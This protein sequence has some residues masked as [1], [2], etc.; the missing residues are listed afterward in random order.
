MSNSNVITVE[1][2]KTFHS[3]LP[4][5]NAVQFKKNSVQLTQQDSN[6]TFKSGGYDGFIALSNDNII[7]SFDS[8]GIKYSIDK[9]ITY[10][11]SNITSGKY[12]AFAELSD[13]NVIASNVNG[14]LIYSTNKGVTWQ[15]LNSTMPACK[16]FAILSD[17]TIIAGLTSGGIKRSTDK[18]VTWQDSSETTIIYNI[19]RVLSDDTIVA[20]SYGSYIVKYSTDKG[21][22]WK[23]GNSS[24][25]GFPSDFTDIVVLSDDTLLAGDGGHIIYSKNKGVTW[26]FSNSTMTSVAFAELSDG[27]VIACDQRIEYSTDKGVTWQK[28]NVAYVSS[29]YYINFAVLSDDTVIVTHNRGIKYST[30][31][32]VTWQ[33]SIITSDNYRTLAVLSDDTIIVLKYSNSKGTRVVS[34]LTIEPYSLEVDTEPKEDDNKF[35]TRDMLVDT[36][37]NLVNYFKKAIESMQNDISTLQGKTYEYLG[38]D[39]INTVFDE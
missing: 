19:M 2:L 25:S 30:D 12:F 13:G 11:D 37:N 35:I 1:N 10:Q 22:T 28:S 24:P 29:I 16:V 4:A 5:K 31:K 17:D 36:T 3:L 8:V 7:I 38:A 9:G 21:A 23:V 20:G 34:R 27:T 26:Q 14:G 39:E 6:I 32:G 15:E 33:D 18:G